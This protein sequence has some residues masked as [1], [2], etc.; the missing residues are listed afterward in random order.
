MY[1]QKS[2]KKVFFILRARPSSS[3]I[4]N[5]SISLPSSPSLPSPLLLKGCQGD[6][7]VPLEG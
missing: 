5:S 3:F 1:L 4:G 6:L 7:R 2:K